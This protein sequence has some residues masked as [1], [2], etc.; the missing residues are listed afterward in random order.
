MPT[1]L[2]EQAIRLYREGQHLREVASEVGRS[3]EWVRKTLL[4][5]GESLQVRGAKA[6]QRAGCE[7]CGKECALRSRF[8]SRECF[9]A[10]RLSKAMERVDA[11][12]HVLRMGGTYAEAAEKAGFKSAWH[13]WGRLYHFGLTEGLR[14]PP[15]NSTG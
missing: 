12:M 15:E 6:K 14:P 8:C 1:P 13:L 3:H 9:N 4:K 11:A 5:A 10:L 7:R 2:E